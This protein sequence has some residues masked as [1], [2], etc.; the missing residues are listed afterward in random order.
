MKFKIFTWLKCLIL[1]FNH[2]TF[3]RIQRSLKLGKHVH[4]IPRTCTLK[5]YQHLKSAM[6]PIKM[7]RTH[8]EKDEWHSQHIGKRQII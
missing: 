8:P 7:M 1:N 2:F 5:N 4:S 6:P 3:P